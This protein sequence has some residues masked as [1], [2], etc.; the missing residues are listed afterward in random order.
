MFQLLLLFNIC[1]FL[2]S[3]LLFIFTLYIAYFVHKPL[4]S[5][6]TLTVEHI[7][8]T[9]SWWHFYKA[10]IVKKKKSVYCC[11]CHHLASLSFIHL[12]AWSQLLMHA[13]ISF[14]AYLCLSHRNNGPICYVLY[15]VA[16]WYEQRTGLDQYYKRL[17]QDHEFQLMMSRITPLSS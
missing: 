6:F 9:F 8:F 10:A 4:Y 11:L 1:L 16:S 15:F 5:I 14:D 3:S 17:S 13:P 2:L 12:Y 7:T